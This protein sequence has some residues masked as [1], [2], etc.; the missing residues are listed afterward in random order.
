MVSAKNKVAASFSSDQSRWPRRR[1]F[2]RSPDLPSPQVARFRW[3]LAM[4][5]PA[6]WNGPC[7]PAGDDEAPEGLT[8]LDYLELLARRREGVTALEASWAL[9]WRTASVR[10]A[11]SAELCRQRGLIV[12]RIPALGGVVYRIGP[13]ALAGPL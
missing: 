3:R 2:R 6:F 11:I 8:K 13:S 4:V 7:H 9:R 5:D 12:E 1:S 10:S